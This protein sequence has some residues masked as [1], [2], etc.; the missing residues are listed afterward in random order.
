M[1]NRK[2]RRSNLLMLGM[3]IFGIAVLLSSCT[4]E[5]VFDEIH[6]VSAIEN[7]TTSRSNSVIIPNQKFK[8]SSDPILKA[9]TNQYYFYRAFYGGKQKHLNNSTKNDSYDIPLTFMQTDWDNQGRGKEFH[10]K[11]K[12]VI[13]SDSL[14]VNDTNL[15]VKY[16][17]ELSNMPFWYAYQNDEKNEAQ[18]FIESFTS[19]N[20]AVAHKIELNV[21]QWRRDKTSTQVLNELRYPEDPEREPYTYHGKL[22]DY[23]CLWKYDGEKEVIRFRAI[24]DSWSKESASFSNTIMLSKFWKY[25]LDNNP[26]RGGTAVPSVYELDGTELYEDVAFGINQKKP[27]KGIAKFTDFHITFNGE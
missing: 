20:K 7:S 14:K 21:W 6:E 18:I 2:K 15:S 27:S 23:H 17:V 10:S 1:K 9:G 26:N 22:D 12:R 11:I 8:N 13:P 3:L 24:K 4:K 16:K 19:S 25:F 5:T